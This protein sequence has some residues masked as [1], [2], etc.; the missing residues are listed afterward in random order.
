MKRL[1]LCLLL[2]ISLSSPIGSWAGTEQL[3]RVY[4]PEKSVVDGKLYIRPVFLRFE[5][6]NSFSYA[7]F[8]EYN[9]PNLINDHKVVYEQINSAFFKGLKVEIKSNDNGHMKINLDYSDCNEELKKI[10]T[11]SEK[12]ELLEG[13][14]AAILVTDGLKAVTLHT[15]GY[16]ETQK[17]VTKTFAWNKLKKKWTPNLGYYTFN[18]K[19]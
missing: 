6:A 16:F 8:S 2:A 3:W 12:N 5:E 4:I 17:E 18:L 15:K 14:A 7:V 11:T 13:T 1:I 19:M 9:Q 10:K